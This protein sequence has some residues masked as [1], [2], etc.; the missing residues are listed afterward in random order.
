[1]V[2]GIEKFRDHFKDCADQYV[3]I[4]GAACSLIFDEA[5]IPFRATKDLDIVLCIEVLDEAFASRFWEFVEAGRYQA[6]QRSGG[7]REFYRFVKPE[8]D[9]FPFMLELFARRPDAMKLPEGAALSP[10]PVDGDAQSL[11][12]ILLDDNYYAALQ[13]A[14]RKID[15]VSLLDESL[16]I[17]FKAKA[18]L[19]LE[20]RAAKGEKIDAGQIRKHLRDAIRLLQLFPAEAEVRLPDSLKADLAEFS[21][22]LDADESVNPKD[23][24]VAIPKDDCV[25]L[26]RSIYGID[27]AS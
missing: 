4:G 17:P 11:S 2:V 15:G 1:M 20:E 21:E 6:R 13:N 3:L 24:D 14:R 8:A 16:L 18:Y 19:D 23:F 26:L 5:G 25:K 22:K 12:A 27:V 10:I 7:E 9:D